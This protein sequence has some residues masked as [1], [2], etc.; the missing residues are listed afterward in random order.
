MAGCPW[1]GCPTRR[2]VCRDCELAE[3]YDRTDEDRE[4]EGG[5]A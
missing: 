1:C 3:R 2:A 4:D 5:E